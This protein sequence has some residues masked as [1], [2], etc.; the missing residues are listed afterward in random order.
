MKAASVNDIKKKLK[1]ADKAALIEL[2]QRLARSKKENKELLSFLLFEADD[3]PQYIQ[4]V[5]QELDEIFATVNHDSVFF[6][7][8]SLRKAL[9]QANKHIRFTG[10]KTA[11]IEILLH[12]CTN[13]NG[14]RLPWRKSTLLVNM[15]N[16]Q[17]K[18]IRTALDALHEDLQYDYQRA[19]N[20]LQL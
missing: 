19:F 16:S 14:L 9:R 10:S 3:L 11:E 4:E 17:L 15:Y 5:K 7:K 1:E 20:R 6:A 8:K 18:K 2:V 12:Y 13:F